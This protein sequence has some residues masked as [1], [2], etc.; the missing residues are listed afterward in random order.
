MIIGV[1]KIDK[2]GKIKF[3][4]VKDHQGVIISIL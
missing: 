3:L 2:Y 4:S 1:K